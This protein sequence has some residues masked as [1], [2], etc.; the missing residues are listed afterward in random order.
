MFFIPPASSFT[1]PPAA[2]RLLGYTKRELVGQNISKFIP[3]PFGSVHHE[4]M[5]RFVCT[6]KEV[7]ALSRSV[8]VCAC[9]VTVAAH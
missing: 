4:F 7:Q 8:P 1:A 9:G 2:L 6:G 5:K 3:E